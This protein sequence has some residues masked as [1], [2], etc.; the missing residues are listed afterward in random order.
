[1]TYKRLPTRWQDCASLSI[2]L[3][4]LVSPWAINYPNDNELVWS[5]SSWIA[6]AIMAIALFTVCLPNI[7]S[8]CL[9][10]GIAAWTIASP[11]I[12]NQDVTAP[13]QRLYQLMMIDSVLAS[14]FLLVFSLWVIFEDGRLQK[15]VLRGL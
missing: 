4:L 2:G 6:T 1:M 11:L 8:E 9:I 15:M 3:W 13:D 5:V 14:V 10:F 7:W 12:V